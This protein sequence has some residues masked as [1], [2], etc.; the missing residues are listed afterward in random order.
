MVRRLLVTAAL[1]AVAV[2]VVVP[3]GAGAATH[4]ACVLT[5]KADIPQGL[6]TKAKAITFG[7]TGKFGSCQ[8]VTGVK[9]GT[10]S[11][12]GAGTGSCVG[13]NTSGSATV[14]W[15][16]GQYSG[17]SFTT[18]GNGVIVRVTARFTS[19]LFAGTNAKAVL[20]FYTTTPQAC[21]TPAGLKAASFAGPAELG[22]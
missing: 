16:N 18:A 13:N 15:N 7:F 22:V 14:H 21:N 11:A 3:G 20:L 19:G 4:G 9:S 2:V 12:N 10:V 6:T 5:G 8:G 1:A 17:L